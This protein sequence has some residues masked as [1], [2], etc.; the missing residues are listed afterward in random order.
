MAATN[1][2]TRN[3]TYRKLLG[4]GLTYCVPRFQRDYSWGEEEWDDLWQDILGTIPADGEPAQT[5]SKPWRKMWTRIS[6]SRSRIRRNGHR[7]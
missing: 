6:P 5:Y 1:F 3:D 4:N 7:K 2:N